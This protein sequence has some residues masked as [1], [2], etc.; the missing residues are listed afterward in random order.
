MAR[1]E[2]TLYFPQLRHNFPLEHAASNAQYNLE[3]LEMNC[4]YQSLLYFDGVSLL[5]INAST[6]KNSSEEA[7]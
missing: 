4:R 6:I 3:S 2:H 1:N 7:N 5:G